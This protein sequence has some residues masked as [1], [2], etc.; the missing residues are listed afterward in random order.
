MQST[1]R[2]SK[3]PQK[4]RKAD[5]RTRKFWTGVAIGLVIIVIPFSYHIY[6]MAPSEEGEVW[7]TWF[8]T[9]SPGGYWSVQ[10]FL[11]NLFGKVYLLFF[12]S[13]FYLTS[14]KAWKWSLLVPLTVHL[15]Q[16]VAVL[17]DNVQYVDQLEFIDSLPIIIPILAV[18]T[19]IAQKLWNRNYA[20]SL[21]E[22]ID[23]E[24]KAITNTSN[25]NSND[26]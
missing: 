22:D 12:I 14:N 16:L 9:I 20:L 11:Y 2:K 19:Y 8:G 13:L 5:L 6:L 7:N 4:D 18:Q 21:T 26:Q 17:N 10:A 3:F 23:K 1:K 24:L 25:I 15:Y